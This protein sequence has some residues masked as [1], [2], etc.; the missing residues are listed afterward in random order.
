MWKINSSFL[1]SANWIH[2]RRWERLY[3]DTY[4]IIH[5]NNVGSVVIISYLKRPDIIICL[6][7]SVNVWGLCNTDLVLMLALNVFWWTD[8]FFNLCLNIASNYQYARAFA[9]NSIIPTSLISHFWHF[10][11]LFY[12]KILPM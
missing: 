5:R 12:Y 2:H 1:S 11:I 8:R 3:A 6:A 4:K 7:Y 9:G 10:N